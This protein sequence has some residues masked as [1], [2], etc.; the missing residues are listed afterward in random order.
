MHEFR[1]ESVWLAL[2]HLEEVN[3]V[4]VIENPYIIQAG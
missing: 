1:C 4:L 2:T 3:Y